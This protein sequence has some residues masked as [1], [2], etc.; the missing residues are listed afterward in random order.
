MASEVMRKYADELSRLNAGDVAMQRAM[1]KEEHEN[2]Q[3]TIKLEEDRAR[4]QQKIEKEIKAALEPIEP[5]GRINM[6]PPPTEELSRFEQWKKRL[7]MEASQRPHAPSGTMEDWAKLDPRWKNHE[8]YDS[9][10]DK[11]GNR[12]SDWRREDQKTG[13]DGQ[14]F[15]RE[16]ILEIMLISGDEEIQAMGKLLME[17]YHERRS[18]NTRKSEQRRRRDEQ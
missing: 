14:K 4:Q 5:S 1:S 15:S 11:R 18:S 13:M 3:L 7:D 17:R 12:D 2:R 9:G 6:A 16:D 8:A 10:A